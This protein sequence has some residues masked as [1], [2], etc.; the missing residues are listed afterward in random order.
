MKSRDA[1]SC[2]LPAG[3]PLRDVGLDSVAA[4]VPVI[5][6]TPTVDTPE[7]R[8]IKHALRDFHAF[9]SR[10]ETL[11]KDADGDWSAA[12][13]VARRLSLNLEQWLTP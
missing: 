12:A 10:A 3:H 13:D 2:R 11:F 8:F 4:R 5:R 1:I 9:V 6:K 7:N